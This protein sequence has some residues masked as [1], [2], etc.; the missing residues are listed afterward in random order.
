MKKILASILAAASV[1]TMSAVASASELTANDPTK[2]V[3]KG[4]EFSYDVNATS[5]KVVFDV[6]MPAKLTAWLNPYNA[7]LKI[8][9]KK[10]KDDAYDSA[11]PLVTAISADVTSSASVGSVAYRVINR[12]TEYAVSIDAKATTTVNTADEKPWAVEGNTVTPGTKGA[13]VQLIFAGTD[14]ELV[15]G[16]S[17]AEPTLTDKSAKKS[18]SA[19]GRLQL[20]SKAKEN[21][22]LGLEAGQVEQKA[23]GWLGKATTDATATTEATKYTALGQGYIQF[24]GL[25]AKSDETPGAEKPVNWT[26]DDSININVIFKLNVGKDSLS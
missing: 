1:L 10:D 17:G 13:A 21:A 4:D 18:A 8:V 24:V 14:S 5:P 25:L 22:K 3:T 7:N 20:D 26:T 16:A 23:W 9:L 2:N 6:L 15:K 11:A 19:A 12:S